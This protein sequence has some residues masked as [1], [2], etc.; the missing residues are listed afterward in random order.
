MPTPTTL[1]GTEPP[2]IVICPKCK[3]RIKASGWW[4]GEGNW[5]FHGTCGGCGYEFFVGEGAGHV[6]A[7]QDT[8]IEARS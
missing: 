4:F 3:G 2:P 8:P 5:R 7:D 1:Q 6:N